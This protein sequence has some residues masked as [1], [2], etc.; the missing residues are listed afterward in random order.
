ML[1]KVVWLKGESLIRTVTERIL[2]LTAVPNH[3]AICC[4]EAF[5]TPLMQIYPFNYDCMTFPL[6]EYRPL[7]P[8]PTLWDVISLPLV[9]PIG[10]PKISLTEQPHD[11]AKPEGKTGIW[12]IS[13]KNRSWKSHSVAM[14]G[15]PQWLIE[16]ALFPV[17][18]C[19]LWLWLLFVLCNVASI[20]DRQNKN[21]VIVTHNLHWIFSSLPLWCSL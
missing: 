16:K 5:T 7:T 18:V 10:L 9:N 4:Q 3:L 19:Y 1:G 8:N 12:N 13:F 2:Y 14:K 6:G 20:Q 15:E 17:V 21:E 11:N